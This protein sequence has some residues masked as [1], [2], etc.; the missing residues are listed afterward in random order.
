M[1][2]PSP[3]G[4]RSFFERTTAR[5]LVLRIGGIRLSHSSEKC[6]LNA[7]TSE[8][9]ADFMGNNL[10]FF[11]LE[12]ALAKVGSTSQRHATTA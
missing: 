4:F 5:G 10:V 7:K 1:S 2:D 9:G 3:K 12:H 6:M 8:R 11:P